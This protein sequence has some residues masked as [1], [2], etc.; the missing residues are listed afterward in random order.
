MHLVQRNVC[1]AVTPPSVPA[2]PAIT[3][4]SYAHL[5]PDAQ[6]DALDRLG[7]QVARIADTLPC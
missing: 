7:E 2:N 1:E 6:R 4:S 3:L 5:L